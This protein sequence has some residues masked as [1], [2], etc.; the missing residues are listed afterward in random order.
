MSSLPLRVEQHQHQRQG[1]GRLAGRHGEDEDHE[2]LAAPVVVKAAPGDEADRHA[3]QHHLGRQEHDDHV[4][5]A[6]KA[7]QADAEQH[8]ADDQVVLQQCELRSW[9]AASLARLRRG[10]RSATTIA[11]APTSATNSSVPATS[12]AIRCG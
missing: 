3:L 8:G 4:P 9:H 11:T 2:H 6:E 1:D 10:L 5:P 7:D 12:T